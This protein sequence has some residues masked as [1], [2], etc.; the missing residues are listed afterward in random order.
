MAHGDERRA[1]CQF[2]PLVTTLGW[3]NAVGFS[4]AAWRVIIGLENDELG[5]LGS[6]YRIFGDASVELRVG[7]VAVAELHG[8]AVGGMAADGHDDRPGRDDIE[9]CDGGVC[10]AVLAAVPWKRGAARGHA[11]RNAGGIWLRRVFAAVLGAGEGLDAS[12]A[13]A[14]WHGAD[15]V[16]LW[17][18]RGALRRPKIEIRNS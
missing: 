1:R 9:H 12:G 16:L 10:H 18:V 4:G 3:S 2:V 15:G 7:L 5:G 13:G 11:N 8:K 14:V 6:K 17:D